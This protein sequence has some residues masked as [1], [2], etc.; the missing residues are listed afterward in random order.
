MTSYS[1]QSEEDKWTTVINKK[2]QKKET[3]IKV[4]DDDNYMKK[5]LC[6]NVLTCGECHYGDKCMYAHNLSEQNV[7]SFRKKAYDI[8]S[9]KEKIS[10][11]PDKE[12]TKALLQLSKVCEDCIKNKCPGGY[13][14]KYGA[15]DKKFQV[16]ADDLRYGICYN[17]TC[18]CVHLTNKGLIP[19]NSSNT[20]N[21]PLRVISVNDKPKNTN[22]P[23]GTI[24][25][26]DFFVKLSSAGSEHDNKSNKSN[27]IKQKNDSD[28]KLHID[29]DDDDDET[30]ETMERIKE[31][32]DH[33]SDSDKSC[34][35]S[36]FQ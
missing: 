1:Q 10:Y 20:K 14:C 26:D 35:D 6:N 33:N 32:L 11:K 18:N 16:C 28:N 5:M 23:T 27:K 25:S 12:L 34:N 29:D 7:D 3:F 30:A 24:L 15:L 19:L 9:G 8:I 4:N 21:Q 36:I 17:T 2:I 22:I 13:N 31:Y